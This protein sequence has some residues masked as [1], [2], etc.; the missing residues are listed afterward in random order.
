[1][2]HHFIQIDESVLTK[3]IQQSK[4]EFPIGCTKKF[5]Q[6]ILGRA[7]KIWLSNFK[8]TNYLKTFYYIY[9]VIDY[10]W[11]AITYI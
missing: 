5:W 6:V 2:Y 7:T 1:M 8:T 10:E 3:R 4:L 11:L 9:D